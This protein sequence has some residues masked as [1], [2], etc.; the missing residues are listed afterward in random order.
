MWFGGS[1]TTDGDLSWLFRSMKKRGWIVGPAPK[2]KPEDFVDK[3]PDDDDFEEFIAGSAPS[4]A[5]SVPATENP[6]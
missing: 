6:R 3:W 2:E 4:A 5:S 1:D